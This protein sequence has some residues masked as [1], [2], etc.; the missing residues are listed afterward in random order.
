VWRLPLQRLQRGITVDFHGYPANDYGARRSVAVVRESTSDSWN[1]HLKYA[2]PH[3]DEC[4]RLAAESSALYLAFCGA[5]E[6]LRTTLKN[7]P[8]Y[9]ERL[10]QSGR[11][12][13]TQKERRDDQHHGTSLVQFTPLC[14]T[15]PSTSNVPRPVSMLESNGKAVGVA[16]DR[17]RGMYGAR[18][19]QPKVSDDSGPETLGKFR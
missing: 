11:E 9:L 16:S 19:R 18:L 1:R 6:A 15:P 14:S 7:S 8:E 12:R 2:R 13:E 17:R 4:V 3:C 10:F 5:D